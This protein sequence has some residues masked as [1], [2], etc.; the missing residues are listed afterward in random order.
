MEFQRWVRQ[1][2]RHLLDLASALVV[3][4]LRDQQAALTRPAMS[5]EEMFALLER[6]GLVATVAELRRVTEGEGQ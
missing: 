3:A 1:F 6:I 4:A 2:V 5:M